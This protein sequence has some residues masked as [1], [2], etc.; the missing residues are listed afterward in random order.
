MRQ[1]F[2]FGHAGSAAMHRGTVTLRVAWFGLMG[3]AF[4]AEEVTLP[5]TMAAFAR[6]APKSVG[7]AMSAAVRSRRSMVVGPFAF[8][9]TGTPRVGRRR[10]YGARHA[11][12]KS[13]PRPRN[14]TVSVTCASVPPAECHRCKILRHVPTSA[15]AG[16]S[17]A[18]GATRADRGRRALRQ[19]PSM[20]LALRS[21]RSAA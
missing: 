17:A 16:A 3:Q 14:R 9:G 11:N 13:A 18:T 2:R 10:L 12:A 1:T 4:G 19:G 6:A 15:A 5:L 8:R 20:V 7:R 21:H